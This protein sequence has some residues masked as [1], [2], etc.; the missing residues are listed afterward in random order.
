MLSNRRLP[1]APLIAPA[2]A[3][4]LSGISGAALAREAESWRPLA[5]S[6]AEAASAESTSI[7]AEDDTAPRT[8]SSADRLSYTTAFDALRRGDLELAR[9]SARQANDRVLLGQV[10]FERLFHPDYVATYEELAAWLEDYSGLPSAER[11]YTLALRRRPDGAPEPR[12]PAGIGGRTWQNVVAAGGGSTEDDPAKAARVMLNHDDLNNAYVTGVQIGDWWT[13]AL[14]AYRMNDFARSFQA[15]ERVAADP[16]EDPWVRA[17]AGVWAAKAAAQSGRNDRV[18]PYLRLAAQWPATFYGQIALRQLGE[19]AVVHNQGP[20][21]Y[22]AGG[23]QQTAY[24]PG[25]GAHEDSGVDAHEL[26]AFI[27]SDPQARR[28]VALYEVGRRSESRTEL[29]A[30]LRTAAG[31]APRRMW[32]GLA[33]SLG[34]RVMASDNDV[35]TIDASRF[36]TPDLQP[37]GGFTVERSLVYALARKE[38]SFNPA[39]RSAV[40]AYGLMQV[41]PG[42]AAEMTGDQTFVSQPQKLLE[43]G[44]NMRLGQTYI[45]RMLARPEFQGDLLRAVASYNAGPGPM[46][47]AL[48]R[49]GPNPD[50]LLLIE[51]IDVPQARDYVEKVVAAYWVYQRM[52][53]GPL[54]TLDAVASGAGLVPVSLDYVAPPPQAQPALVPAMALLTA[55][56]GGR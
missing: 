40:G 44:V 39:A 17:G 54:N 24:A 45:N 1:F 14:A 30:G 9:A 49:L 33:R 22:S 8:L 47:N 12:R 56:S 36:A 28:T 42:T 46:L 16:T 15:F 6:T 19:E 55:T 7:S 53:G 11:V 21:P 26:N 41:M 25:Q 13:A 3:L 34:P 51:T 43:P 2:L 29:T 32:L 31:E 48:R 35:R 20:R 37:E 50:P 27:Q 18:Q 5:T 52:F 10:E 23:Y 38:T 4:C